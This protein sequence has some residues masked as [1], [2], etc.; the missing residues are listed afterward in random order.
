M[1]PGKNPNENTMARQRNK[2]MLSNSNNN[3]QTLTQTWS[4]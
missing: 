1:N 2:H 3:Q 4:C